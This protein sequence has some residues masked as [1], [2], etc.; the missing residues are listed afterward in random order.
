[1]HRFN[2]TRIGIMDA[3]MNS[4]YYS[5]FKIRELPILVNALDVSV[6]FKG[7]G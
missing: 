3:Q 6:L 1:M 2:E 7:Y 5:L 4:C